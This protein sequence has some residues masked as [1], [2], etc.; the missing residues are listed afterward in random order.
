[1]KLRSLVALVALSVAAFASSANAG[2]V[3]W[4]QT[5]NVA[6]APGNL[7]LT[8]APGS[9]GTLYLFGSSD[10]TRVG[11]VGFNVGSSNAGMTFTAPASYGP[12]NSAAWNL[13]GGPI[14][15]TNQTVTGIG[16]AAL[17]PAGSGFGPGSAVG[18]TM[19]LAEWGYKLG[20]TLGQSSTLSLLV[21][22]AGV[23]DFA[24]N[25]LVFTAGSGQ[26]TLSGDNFGGSLSFGSATVQ[27]IPEPATLAM[28][29]LAM[30]G[31]LGLRRRS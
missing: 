3:F 26:S 4:L 9:T 21:G 19:E 8:G 29:G 10:T 25:A 15:V 6:G 24:G 27:S 2:S 28:V 31:G 22:D 18:N 23:A 20:S 11:G 14:T 16:G 7:N 1:M 13:P 12:Q 5:S 17:P 30:I